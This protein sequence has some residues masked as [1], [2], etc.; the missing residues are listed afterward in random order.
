VLDASLAAGWCFP[1]DLDVRL[2]EPSSF[3]SVFGLA[4]LHG[5]TVYDA[6]YLEL[7]LREGAPLASLDAALR[8]AASKAGVVLFEIPQGA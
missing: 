1:E 2:Y 3:D 8:N 4:E 7:A 5:L 6:A